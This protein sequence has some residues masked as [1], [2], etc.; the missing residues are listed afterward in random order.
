[1]SENTKWMSFD[2][3]RTSGDE[4]VRQERELFT[5]PAAAQAVLQPGKLSGMGGWLPWPDDVAIAKA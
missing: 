3:F 5:D 1:M 4:Q 2:E